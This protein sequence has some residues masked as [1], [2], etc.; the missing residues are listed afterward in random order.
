MP[1]GPHGVRGSPRASS[2]ERSD[3]GRCQA[4][5]V[6]G[7]VCSGTRRKWGAQDRHEPHAS[8]V[9][10]AEEHC[11][12][13]TGKDA[14]GS[15]AESGGM[16]GV[17]LRRAKRRATLGVLSFMAGVAAVDGVTGRSRRILAHQHLIRASVAP[18]R[19][20]AA[21]PE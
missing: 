10:N 18:V 8:N 14:A 12:T 7:I 4:E 13:D 9:L 1:D 15:E 6:A 16:T 2:L 17:V 20:A 19:A 3:L 11:Q 5:A 21:A